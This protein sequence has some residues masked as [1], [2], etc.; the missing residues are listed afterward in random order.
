MKY[1]L[2]TIFCLSLF[3]ATSQCIIKLKD[4]KNDNPIVFANVFIEKQNYTSDENGQIKVD[5]KKGDVL[6]VSHLSYE[7][8]T[9]KLDFEEGERVIYLKEKE[10]ALNEILVLSR[11]GKTQIVN[12]VNSKKHLRNSILETKIAVGITTL[13]DFSYS[14][15][16]IE[17][18][19]ETFRKKITK[20][21]GSITFELIVFKNGQEESK[22]AKQTFKVSNLPKRKL[23]L[24]FAEIEIKK[25]ED[26]FLV[27]ERIIA[28]LPSSIDKNQLVNPILYY[29][30]F[31]YECNCMVKKRNNDWLQIENGSRYKCLEF[32]IKVYGNYIID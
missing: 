16:K 8:Q 17:I 28:P 10:I 11:G 1:F 24:N 21:D 22:A 5:C 18:P 23:I 15:K 4:F 31:K 9:I 19:Y 2:L 20:N 14:V 12:Q 27:I 3:P 29:D 6:K 13:K 30:P 25:G 32:V 7:S 26:A